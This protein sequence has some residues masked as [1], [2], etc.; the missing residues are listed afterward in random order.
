MII[1]VLF[2]SELLAK[3][4]AVLERARN[5]VDDLSY[6]PTSPVSDKRRSVSSTSTTSNTSLVTVQSPTV[7]KVSPH[8]KSP[9]SS[10]VGRVTSPLSG[11]SSISS[12]NSVTAENSVTADNT[13]KSLSSVTDRSGQVSTSDR[14]SP[15]RNGPNILTLQR[16]REEKKVCNSY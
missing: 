15:V 16:G 12:N 2:S 3:V 10:A 4:D 7:S 14:R 13:S 6:Y 11:R 8:V 9:V 1:F 5:D